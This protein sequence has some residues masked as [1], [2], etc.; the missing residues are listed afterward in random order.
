MHLLLLFCVLCK[1]FAARLLT[2]D[3]TVKSG[4]VIGPQTSLQRVR[5]QGLKASVSQQCIL[6]Q[7]SHAE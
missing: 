6:P 2:L 1:T 3:E 5:Q 7:P 4:I